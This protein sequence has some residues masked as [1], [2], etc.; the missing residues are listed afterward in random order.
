LKLI[1]QLFE[2][3]QVIKYCSLLLLT[4]LRPLKPSFTGTSLTP[5]LNWYRWTLLMHQF[6]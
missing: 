5:H 6:K 3:I 4:Q 1:D 2:S